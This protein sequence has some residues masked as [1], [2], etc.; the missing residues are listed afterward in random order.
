MSSIVT[1]SRDKLLAIKENL[2]ACKQ[3]LSCRRD[4]LKKLWVEGVEHKHVL[5]LL[6]EMLVN[7]YLIF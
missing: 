2:L 4:E 3:L 5:Q 7:F 6:E 1:S